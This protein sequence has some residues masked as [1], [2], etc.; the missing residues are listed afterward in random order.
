LYFYHS[1]VREMRRHGSYEFLEL[2][3]IV[4]LS[5]FE[6]SRS[7][8]RAR[9]GFREA[10]LISRFL[11]VAS[12]SCFA[13]GATSGIASAQTKR[14]GGPTPA[15]A[16]AA[17]YFVDLKDGDTVPTKFTVHFGLKGMGVAPAGTGKENSGHHHLLI[18]TELPPM[19]QPVPAD[20]N[21]LH[22]AAGQTE[23]EITLPPGEH[24]LQLL[25]G[26]KNHVP[27]STPLY[28]ERIHVKVVEGAKSVS[29]SPNAPAQPHEHAAAGAPGEQSSDADDD[30]LHRHPSPPGAKEYFVYPTNGSYITP[31]PVIRFGLVGMGVAPAGF[32]KANTGHHHLLVDTDLP[33][34]D[35]PIPNDFNHLH[36]AAG[37]TEAKINLPLGKH[38]LQLL[39]GDENH[40]PHDPPVY[41]Q[42]IEVTV[43]A[44]GRRPVRPH[45]NHRAHYTE[46]GSG[47]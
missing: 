14:V 29:S 45:R 18:D 42:P 20:F 13:L 39:L 16:G 30:E 36:F 8:S 24:T 38:K 40:V 10:V 44:T 33:P 11:I 5:F 28:S 21:H 22:F 37:Q 31:T 7:R 6:R 41:S 23:A 17:V 2:H 1:I 35:L 9:F 46:Y 19:D 3:S 26:D 34:F 27:N 32:E 43:T 47:R 12:I 4:K 15:P 25:L